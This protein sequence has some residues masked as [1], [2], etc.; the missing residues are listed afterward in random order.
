MTIMAVALV[1][2]GIIFALALLGYAIPFLSFIICIYLGAQIMGSWGWLVGLI[3]GA[4][5]EE[6]ISTVAKKARK[7]SLNK[8]LANVS[9]L[10]NPNNRHNLK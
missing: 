2:L 5:I 3:I 10:S 7:P 9:K 6:I 4:I 1:I 8:A